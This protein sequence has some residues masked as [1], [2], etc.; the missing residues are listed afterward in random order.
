MNAI[1]LPRTELA[2]LQKKYAEASPQE[3]VAAMINKEFTGQ[4]ALASSFGAESAVLLHLVAQVDRSTPVIMLETGKLFGETKKYRDQLVNLLGLT[5]VRN[6]APDPVE[7]AKQ[8][9]KG[10]LWSQNPDACC[11]VRKVA[12]LE[13]ALD[14]FAAWFTGRKSFQAVTRAN[15]PKVEYEGGKFKVNPLVGMSR[16]DVDAYFETYDLPRHPL[17]ADGYLSIGCMP[18][19]D[20]VAAGEDPRSGRWRGRDKVECGIHM[21]LVG[22]K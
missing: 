5:D 14:P 3:L 21:P 16:D 13:R 2:T 1:V 7:L 9:P 10:V 15:L 8:D 11:A 19:T 22:A 6:A 4:I 20:R 12:V 18:C 17:E